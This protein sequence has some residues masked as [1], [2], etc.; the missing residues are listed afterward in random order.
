MAF[1]GLG[2]GLETA[3]ED[4][5]TIWFVVEAEMNGLINS[6]YVPESTIQSGGNKSLETTLTYSLT[7]SNT[8]L[9]TQHGPRYHLMSEIAVHLE[10]LRKLPQMVPFKRIIIH[11]LLTCFNCF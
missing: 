2:C 8:L 3:N 9:Q 11:K 7:H 10:I 1:L 6:G 5:Q 4:M